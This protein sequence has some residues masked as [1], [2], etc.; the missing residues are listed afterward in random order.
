MNAV[1]RTLA[2]LIGLLGLMGS[3]ALAQSEGQTPS[4][5]PRPA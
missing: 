4:Q 1:V 3:L 2:I 5:R